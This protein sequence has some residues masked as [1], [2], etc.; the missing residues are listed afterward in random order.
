[1]WIRF[2][3]RQRLH[4]LNTDKIQYFFNYDADNYI[5][6]DGNP[7]I[8]YFIS[9]ILN[10]GESIHAEFGKDKILRDKYFHFLLDNLVPNLHNE[11]YD[12]LEAHARL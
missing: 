7:E 1:M 10:D 8:H 3:R 11:I 9:F 2:L 4:G 5:D 12:L 6:K